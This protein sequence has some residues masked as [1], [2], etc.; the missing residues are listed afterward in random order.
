LWCVS[1]VVTAVWNTESRRRLVRTPSGRSQ[2][3]GAVRRCE[4]RRERL[5]GFPRVVRSEDAVPRM[6]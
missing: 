5:W 4:V 2:S 3:A 6:L 1:T